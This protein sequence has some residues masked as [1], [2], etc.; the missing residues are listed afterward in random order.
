MDAWG[1]WFLLTLSCAF[2]SQFDISHSTA[3]SSAEQSHCRPSFSLVWPV[4]NDVDVSRLSH[5]HLSALSSPYFY[6]RICIY[7]G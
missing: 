1:T 6:D 5:G 2:M 4:T 3:V 7:L